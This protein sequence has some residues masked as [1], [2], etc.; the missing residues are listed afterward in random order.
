MSVLLRINR[1]HGGYNRTDILKDISLDILENDFLGLIG[2]NGSGKT[3]LLRLATRIIKP[4]AGTIEFKGRDIQSIELKEFCRSVAFV[5]QE[6][7]SNF[8][9]TVMEIVL[10]GR[11]PHQSRLGAETKH[12]RRIALDALELTD[13]AGLKNKYI[14]ELSAGERQRVLIAKALAQEPGL[15]F[16]D[17]PPSH[18]DIGHQIQILDLL[19]R[20]NRNGKVTI[21][22]VMH[23][24]NLASDYC[25]RIA[26]IHKGTIYREG[27]PQTVLTYQNIEPVYN[28]VVLVHTNPVTKQP[29]VL[30]VPGE[31]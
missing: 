16:L 25:S 11:L 29:N 19:K 10:M 30:L 2:P 26:L 1:V 20:L 17:E 4:S 22:M 12:D 21:V 31:K 8:T 24:L 6:L 3:T 27:T 23:D 13:I 15:F 5:S 18:L 14:D 9:F 28:T 7:S